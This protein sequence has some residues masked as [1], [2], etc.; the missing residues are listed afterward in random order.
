MTKTNKY[1]KPDE[2]VMARKENMNIVVEGK[3]SSPEFN[4]EMPELFY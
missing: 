4:K 2:P 1:F 3:Y